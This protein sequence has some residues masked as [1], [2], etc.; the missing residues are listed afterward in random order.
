MLENLAYVEA[1]YSRYR[2]DPESV[3]AEWRDYFRNAGAVN[4]HENGQ[5]PFTAPLISPARLEPAA[6]SANLDEK[7]YMLVRNYRVRGHKIAAIDPLGVPRPV[8]TELKLEFYNFA[9][10]ELD[11]LINIPTLHFGGPLTI[12]EIFNRLQN[13]Y[14]RSIGAQFMHIDDWRPREWLQQ[15]MESTQNRVM[16]SREEQ[17]RILTR[18]TD[19]V[20]FEEFLRKKFLGAKTFSLEGCETLLPLMDLAIERAGAH[21]VRDIVIGMAHRGR[22]NIL[23]HIAGKDPCAIFREFA[24]ATPEKWEGRGDV[25]HHLGYSGNWTTATGQNIH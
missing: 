20:I 17:L 13:T 18:L 4:G 7:L 15:R 11:Q 25:K 5:T 24:D 19:A 16:L 21:G 10:A 12:R 9:E 23:A 2:Q 6:H 1:I 14:S 8:P 22:L 3:G